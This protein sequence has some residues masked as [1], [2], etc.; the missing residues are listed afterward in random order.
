MDLIRQQYTEI[1]KR[2]FNHRDGEI[3]EMQKEYGANYQKSFGVAIVSLQ[4]IA[5]DYETS[6]EL[7]KLLWEFGGREQTIVAAMLE[8]PGKVKIE[9]L[10]NYL[11]KTNT[12]ELWEQITRQLLRKLPDIESNIERWFALEE[13]ILHIFAILSL[14]YLPHL[15]SENLFQ[16]IMFLEVKDGSYLQR[17]LH[18]VL[19]KIGIRSQEAYDIMRKHLKM[20]SYHSSLLEEISEFYK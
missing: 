17:C 8:E 5:A 11:L 16:S 14:G 12:P 19:L 4:T 15:F 1:N 20:R 10:E 18:R 9:E 7:A 2:I 3:R 6:H 13:D